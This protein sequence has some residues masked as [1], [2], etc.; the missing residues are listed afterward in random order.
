MILV[1]TN[2]IARSIEK[3]HLHILTFNDR[4]FHPITEVQALNPF[5]LLGIPRV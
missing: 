5:D 1:D 2:V 4:D 3:G